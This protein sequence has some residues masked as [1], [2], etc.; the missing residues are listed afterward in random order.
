MVASVIKDRMILKKNL[1]RILLGLKLLILVII[2]L[3][4]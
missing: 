4:T 1:I 3:S 2:D